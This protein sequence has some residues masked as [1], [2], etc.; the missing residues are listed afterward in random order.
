MLPLLDASVQSSAVRTFAVGCLRRCNLG[1]PQ[2][3]SLLLQ[4]VQSLKAESQ[5]FSALFD[6]LMKASLGD[7]LGVGLALFWVVTTEMD[8]AEETGGLHGVG[9]VFLRH[10]LEYLGDGIL[11]AM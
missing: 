10:F 6:F 11:R 1:G 8:D 5:C 2:L 7:P 4:L 3:R 9:E